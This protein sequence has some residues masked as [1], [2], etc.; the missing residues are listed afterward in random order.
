M[1]SSAVHYCLY[2]SPLGPLLLG[3]EAGAL[4]FLRFPV[5]QDDTGDVA[6]GAAIGDD[7]VEDRGRFDR[8]CF[9]LDG[10]FSG[11]L[12]YFSTPYALSGTAFQKKVWAEL[13]TIPFGTLR[14]YGDVAR[15]IGQPGA[16]RAVG[17]ANN[18]NPLPILVPCHRVIGAD[19]RLVGFGGGLDIKIRLLEHEGI[20]PRQVM[21]P[22]QL[23]FGF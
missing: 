6:P 16:S 13:A 22:N 2:D 12:K 23:G 20:D 19:G 14:S 10:Y 4:S 17:L 1:P 15:S 11:T 5:K 3:G 8:V 9:E 21:N 7:W 18:A